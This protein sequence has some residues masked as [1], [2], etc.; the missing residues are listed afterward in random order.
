M[1]NIVCLYNMPE[2]KGCYILKQTCSAENYL[3]LFNIPNGKYWCPK[4]EE[5]RMKFI[6]KDQLKE[7]LLSRL[8]QVFIAR[9]LKIVWIDEELIPSK[10]S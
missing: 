6:V 1:M 2:T 7:V 10:N 9:N 4:T 3:M 5:I 8:M